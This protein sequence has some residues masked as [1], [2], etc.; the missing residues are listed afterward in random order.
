LD[1]ISANVLGLC[2][3]WAIEEEIFNFEQKFAPF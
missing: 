3:G 1:K 2:D